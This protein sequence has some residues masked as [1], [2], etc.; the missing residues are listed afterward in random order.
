MVNILTIK[1]YNDNYIWLIKDSQSQHCIVVDPG[2]A[3]P[4][5]EVL[6]S[7]EL[8]IDAIL[9]THHHYDHVDGVEKLLAESDQNIPVYS[10]NKLFAQS[11]LVE[12]GQQL[13]FFDSR[14][15]F[16]VME[17]PGHTLDH[18]A[19]YNE[20]LIFCGDTLFSAGCGRLFEGTPEQMYSSLSRIAQLPDSTK[21]YCAHEYTQNNLVFAHHLEPK[22]QMIKEYI[23]SAAKQRQ[24][25]VSTIPTTIAL[26]KAVNPFL[27]CEKSSLVNSLQSRLA[28]RLDD[29]LSCFTALRNYK[30]HF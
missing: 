11:L 20:D 29:P 15:S 5:L 10:K 18:L 7:Q 25:G 6:A 27:R 19:Y 8:I 24:Q 26:E 9:L 30:D 2:D 28:E 4:V 14:F 13:H 3:V 1:A 17:V 22:N 21:V 16:T 23:Q 12:E